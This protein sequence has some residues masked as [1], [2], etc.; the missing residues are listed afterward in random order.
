MNIAIIGNGIS[1]IT[2]ARWI[3]KLSDHSI[4]VISSESEHFYS[5][6]ALMYIYMG[7]MRYEDTKPYE[8]WFWKKNRIDLIKDHVIS[9]ST[10]DHSITLREGGLLKYDKLII[11]SGSKSNKFGWPG[12]DLNGVNGLYHLQDLE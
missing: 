8:D 1:G 11:A 10:D 2:A 9:I 5:R 6:T 4:T 12:Q 3:R 7:H